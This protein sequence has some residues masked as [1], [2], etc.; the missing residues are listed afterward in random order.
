MQICATLAT[1]RQGITEYFRAAIMDALAECRTASQRRNTLV[2][3]IKTNSEHSGRIET[4]LTRRGGRQ[5]V[6]TWTSS[7]IRSVADEL[8]EF[9]TH[10]LFT[11]EQVSKTRLSDA[12]SLRLTFVRTGHD[13]RQHASQ[14]SRVQS[15]LQRNT[16]VGLILRGGTAREGRGDGTGTSRSPSGPWRRARRAMPRRRLARPRRS[17]QPAGR[18]S[19]AVPRLGPLPS[20]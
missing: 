20:A 11:V 4:L 14:P 8:L 3:A 19:P 1:A 10:L 7:W 6:Q 18:A 5:H 17:R 13:G 9:S 12:R 15:T 16:R 2:H